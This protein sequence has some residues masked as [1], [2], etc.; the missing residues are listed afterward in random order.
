MNLYSRYPILMLSLLGLAVAGPLRGQEPPDSQIAMMIRTGASESGAPGGAVVLVRLGR[1]PLIV[2]FGAADSE[3]RGIDASTVFRVGSVS[4]VLTATTIARMVIDG[5]LHLDSD[6][7]DRAPWVAAAAGDIPLT[8]RQLL[9]HSSGLEDFATGMFA[10]EADEIRPLREYLSDRLPARSTAAGRWTR[11]SNHGAALAGWVAADA[12]GAS[13][14]ASVE[15]LVLSPLGMEDSGFQQPI[16]SRLMPRMARAFPCSDRDCE[17]LTLDYRHTVPAGAFVTTP[18]DMATF[19]TA[20]V[21]SN[22]DGPLS[23]IRELLFTRAWGAD[24][25][26]PGLS[27][28]LQEQPLAG[29]TAYVHSG[30]SSGYKALL[31]LVPET[32]SALFVVTTGGSSAFGRGAMQMFA[33]LQP[34]SGPP[35]VKPAP[36]APE[37]QAA[38]A[39]YYLLGR[40]SLASYERF[41]GLFLFNDHLAFDDEGWLIRREAGRMVRYGRLEGDLFAEVGG[42]GRLGFERD[43][44]G[45]VVAV[46]AA[47][48][49]FGVRY[50]ATWIRLP[51]WSAPSFMN[52]LLSL[53]VAGPMLLLAAWLLSTIGRAVAFSLKS[54]STQPPPIAWAGVALAATGSV[55]MIIVAFGFM[56]RF[57]ALA[58]QDPQSL[59]YGL[60]PELAGTL[61]FVWPTALLALLSV[62][63]LMRYARARRSM[64]W[65]DLGVTA[66]VSFCLVGFVALMIH[67][68]LLPPTG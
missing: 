25:E 21:T 43:A 62:L 6:L 56:A 63:N 29:V 58:A 38:L 27:L 22:A 60:P 10:R 18:D 9:T 35:A 67:F 3:G 46:H 20:L 40:A 44:A 11:Y 8:L 65:I 15:D 30:S 49:F 54:P 39:G 12:W 50:P 23:D 36:V 1:A 26:L 66:I 13:F 5:R 24:D 55:S 42:S 19:M 57:N 4:K 28:F 31:A 2:T 37:E 52:E 14:A 61:W 32:E 48:E 34:R 53:L 41:P 64:R 16:P 51:F 17:P 33:A 45:S 59:A 68:H 47:D 7:R